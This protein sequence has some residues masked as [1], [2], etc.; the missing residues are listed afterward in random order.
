MQS[1]GG[2]PSDENFWKKL[3]GS[4]SESYCGSQAIHVW[5]QHLTCLGGSYQTGDENP[6]PKAD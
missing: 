4:M 3:P 1:Y 6:Y 5:V 2:G